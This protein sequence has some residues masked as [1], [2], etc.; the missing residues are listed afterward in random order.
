MQ[1]L[2]NKELETKNKKKRLAELEQSGLVT[3]EHML[4]IDR[5]ELTQ[6]L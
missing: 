6:I 5:A 4:N 1:K 2:M 3:L